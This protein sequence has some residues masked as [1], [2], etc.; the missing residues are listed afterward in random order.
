M[1]YILALLS[2]LMLTNCGGGY[3][4]LDLKTMLQCSN[5]TLVIAANGNYP[6]GMPAWIDIYPDGN[7]NR[8]LDD[9]D[10]ITYHRIMVML[11]AGEIYMAQPIKLDDNWTNRYIFVVLHTEL[12]SVVSTIGDCTPLRNTLTN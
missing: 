7:L 2:I 3:N 5:Q 11:Q 6:K 1:K 10:R 8:V 4:P 9:S 12:D